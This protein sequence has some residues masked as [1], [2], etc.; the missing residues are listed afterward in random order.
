MY[1]LSVNRRHLSFGSPH[2]SVVSGINGLANKGG[3]VNRHL[4][5]RAVYGEGRRYPHR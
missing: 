5:D 4:G 3:K 1:N 2:L